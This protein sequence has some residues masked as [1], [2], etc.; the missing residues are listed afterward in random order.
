MNLW[1]LYRYSKLKSMCQSNFG[2]FYNPEVFTANHPLQSQTTFISQIP[3]SEYINKKNDSILC[4]GTD[5]NPELAYLKCLYEAIERYSMK[6]EQPKI[7]I[8][9]QSYN[10]LKNKYFT[11]HP[12]IYCQYVNPKKLSYLYNWTEYNK[13]VLTDWTEVEHAWLT[14]KSIL[15]VSLI[16][17][18]ALGKD[19]N[20]KIFAFPSSNGCAFHYNLDHAKVSALSELI[21]RHQF[22]LAW[23]TFSSGE[24]IILNSDLYDIFPEFKSLS[25]N[26]LKK[27]KLYSL[28]FES[29]WPVVIA[30]FWGD[31]IATPTFLVC[32]ASHYDPTTCIKKALSEL[33]MSLSGL[34]LDHTNNKP[35]SD[36]LNLFPP[37]DT[38]LSFTDRP[39]YYYSKSALNKVSF[40]KKNIK[41][42]TYLNWSNQFK[43]FDDP[44][45]AL[46]YLIQAFKNNKT[47]IFFYNMKNIALQQISGYVIRAIVPEFIPLD[48]MHIARTSLPSKYNKYLYNDLPHPYP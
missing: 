22:L 7:F 25:F 3:A 5:N 1:E 36:Q 29:I 11:T 12:D 10:N 28:T 48:Y 2:L 26:F 39:L 13:T 14:K 37:D 8:K 41:K 6:V 47:D 23:K 42:I 40:W 15:P 34:E 19:Q 38:V 32:G 27:I 21:E 16:Q 45:K 31:G 24:E 17:A 44:T 46:K 33:L 18:R 20:Q 30:T 9:K 35:V 4:I 43:K